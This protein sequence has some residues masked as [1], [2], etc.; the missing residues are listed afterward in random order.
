[1]TN[2]APGFATHPDHEVTIEKHDGE[3]TIMID[4]K[5]IG[6]SRNVL[7]LLESSYDP[8]YYIPLV[9]VEKAALE[10]SDHSTF[11]PFKGTASYW[12]LETTTGLV[13]NAVWGYEA[14]YDEC[15]ALEGHVAF[16]PDKVTI[17][18]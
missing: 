10:K 1:M 17:T 8:V 5:E 16:Y 9:D 6:R 3:V 18:A 7:K 4:E 11:C 2:A 12:H 14:P 15:L 13:E